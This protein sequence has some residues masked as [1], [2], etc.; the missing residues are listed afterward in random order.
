LLDAVLQAGIAIASHRGG[1]WTPGV[2]LPPAEEDKTPYQLR[3]PTG[4]R[5]ILLGSAMT[6][7]VIVDIQP[8][9][10]PE[11]MRFGVFSTDGQPLIVIDNLRTKALGKIKSG[12][13]S[14]PGGSG[15]SVFEEHFIRQ[16]PKSATPTLR[17][18][19]WLVVG[20][21]TRRLEATMTELVRRGAKVELADLAPF[22]NLNAEEALA[23][24]QA[25]IASSSGGAGIL[26]SAG[27]GETLDETADGG[28]LLAAI[29][30]I[31]HQLITLAKVFDRLQTSPDPR[32]ELVVVTSASRLVDG[33]GPM[34][35]TGV[36]ERMQGPW[37]PAARRGRDRIAVWVS[38]LRCAARGDR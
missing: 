11:S 23:R 7:D 38:R 10:E 26:F 8:G 32:S 24:V 33:D 15:S 17:C 37:H 28:Q 29:T 5:K 31:V 35:I 21:A 9:F 6:D 14:L 3:L 34:P 2:P 4:A 22:L 18:A 19:N 27:I 25:F 13:A 12:G 16:E 20:N 1:L 30:P 36:C